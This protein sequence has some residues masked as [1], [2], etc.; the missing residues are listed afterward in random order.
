MEN[1]PPKI[2]IEN[3]DRD[4]IRDRYRDITKTKD[5]DITR[6]KNQEEITLSEEDLPF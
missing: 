3:R 1:F 2:D 6:D 4:K 5:R